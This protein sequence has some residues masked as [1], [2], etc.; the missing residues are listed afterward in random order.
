[1]A[2]I[3]IEPNEPSND[4]QQAPQQPPQ[5]PQLPP[6]LLKVHALQ[7]V[8]SG[9]PAAVSMDISDF[10]KTEEGK[11]IAQ[12]GQALQEAGLGFYKS[13][14]GDTGAIFNQLYIHPQDLQAADKAGKLQ[15]VA[16]P[17]T[18]VDHAISKAGISHPALGHRGPPAAIAAATPMAAPQASA[19]IVQPPSKP[20]PAKA[21]NKLLQARI[22]ASQPAAP[23]AGPAPGGSQLLNS[24]LKPV[25]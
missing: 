20:L 21:Q 25:V 15:Q 5:P 10:A 3:P 6:Q 1:M 19:G 16:P 22:M 8:L 17:W 24:V 12:N 11:A 9:A 7:G 23:T 13:I 18:K 14:H 4:Q 2:E